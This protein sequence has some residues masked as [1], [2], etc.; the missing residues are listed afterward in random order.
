MKKFTFEVPN[1]PPDDYGINIYKADGDKSTHCT[2]CISTDTDIELED[3]PTSIYI[4]LVDFSDKNFEDEIN[5]NLFYSDGLGTQEKYEK[6][7]ND[8]TDRFNELCKVKN[9]SIEIKMED[10][11]WED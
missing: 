10:I 1:T 8:I 7:I 3:I 6:A 5:T 2:I 11:P 9:I 4:S